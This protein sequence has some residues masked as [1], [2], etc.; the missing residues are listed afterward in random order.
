MS[1][2]LVSIITPSY[3]SERFISECIESVLSQ[4]YREWEMIIVDDCSPDN[5]NEIV[6]EY[7]KNESRIKLIKLED[8][9]GPAIA[10]N[11]AIKEAKGRY[12]AFLDADDIWMKDK[13]EKQIGFMQENEIAFSFTEYIKIDEHSNVISDIIERPQKVSYTMML[14][15]NYIPCLTVVYDTQILSKV[16]MPLILKRQDYALWLKLLKKI[17]YAY[18]YKEALAKYRFYSGSLSSNKF[19]AAWYVWKLYREIEKLTIFQSV[20][21][22]V[23]Y[24]IISFIKY[25]K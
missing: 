20:Y 25:K 21:Y 7:M 24:V 17:D 1:H 8:N 22:F 12:I 10:R 2:S 16:Y 11:R 23:H 4:T 5:S 3:K 19:V 15:S 13:L 18:C 6:K 14:K 9:S